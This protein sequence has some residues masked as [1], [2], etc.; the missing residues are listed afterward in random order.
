MISDVS[1]LICLILGSLGDF[2]DEEMPED[3]VDIDVDGA[4]H[5]VRGRCA[6]SPLNNQL[7]EP[8]TE[9]GDSDELRKA[10][11]RRAPPPRYRFQSIL[12]VHTF[13]EEELRLET[14]PKEKK[15]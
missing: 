11:E 10:L 3:L 15:F 5:G 13:A 2:G 12:T 4:A 7:L 6:A 9:L 8:G 14:S 1:D